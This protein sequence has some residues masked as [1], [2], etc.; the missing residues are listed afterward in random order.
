VQSVC[1]YVC[2]FTAGEHCTNDILCV[3]VFIAGEHW[4]S[5][6]LCDLCVFI[7]VCS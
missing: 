4:S 1:V 7:C 3:C 6:I 5:D 2:V